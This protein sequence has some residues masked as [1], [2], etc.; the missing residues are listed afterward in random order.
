AAGAVHRRGAASRR[1][2]GISVIG[3][4]LSGT[5]L[6]IFLVPLFFVLVRRL[7]HGRQATAAAPAPVRRWNA[8]CH[9]RGDSR[10]GRNLAPTP[11]M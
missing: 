10:A 8:G 5:L 3:G 9:P 4:M 1:E 7:L 11:A 2:I 6:A